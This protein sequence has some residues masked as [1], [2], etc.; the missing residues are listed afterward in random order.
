M[1]YL[2]SA[3]CGDEYERFSNPVLVAPLTRDLIAKIRRPLGLFGSVA[4]HHAGVVRLDVE[5]DGVLCFD[6]EAADLPAAF[7]AAGQPNPIVVDV[8]DE[9]DDAVNPERALTCPLA[10]VVVTHGPSAE[11]HVVVE[12]AQGD[13]VRLWAGP[14][15]LEDVAEWEGAAA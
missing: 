9:D 7:A 1:K 2:A 8:P 13:E 4:G 3:L 10:V 14:F 5:L 15:T 6:R 12:D 11:L